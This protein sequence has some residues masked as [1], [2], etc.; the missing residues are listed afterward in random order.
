MKPVDVV[1]I[2]GSL[3]GIKVCLNLREN[4]FEG[5]ITVVS[6]EGLPYERPPLSKSYLTGKTPEIDVFLT[7][8]K[9]LEELNINFISNLSA[10]HLDIASQTVGLSNG[11][12]LSY[13]NLVIASGCKPKI[14]SDIILSER[15]LVLRTLNDAQKLKHLLHG[16]KSLI[17]L[18]AG[19]IGTEVASS[20]AQ[21]GVSVTLVDALEAPL[22]Q[23]LGPKV[24]TLLSKVYSN[25]EIALKLGKRFRSVVEYADKVILTLDDGQQVSADGCLIALGVE[26]ATSWLKGSSISTIG[27]VNANGYLEVGDNIWAVGDLVRY[28]HRKFKESIR[29][30]HYEN[31]LQSASNVARA[32]LGQRELYCPTP[33]FWSD[34]FGLKIQL[35]GHIK[36]DDDVKVIREGDENLKGFAVLYSRNGLCT[37][38]LAVSKPRLIGLS[39]KFIE[40]QRPKNELLEEL[41]K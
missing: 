32:I 33:Y 13:E 28:E 36:P 23:A 18:G 29:S 25:K 41:G 31:A 40:E 35:Q 12:A 4:G 16:I 10:E 11:T 34:Q 1:I 20:A 3:A 19:F 6:Q 22:T 9:K 30:E 7:S 5:P 21:L 8:E 24:A 26:P 2:G 17:V 15:V 38:I 39:A 14:K 37:G 27:G